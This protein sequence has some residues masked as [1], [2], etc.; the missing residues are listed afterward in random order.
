MVS[1]VGVLLR[2]EILLNI[3]QCTGQP[4]QQKKYPVQNVSNA[5]AEKPWVSINLKKT[6]RVLKDQLY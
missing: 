1:S 6:N 5:K 3:L 2:S 4:L